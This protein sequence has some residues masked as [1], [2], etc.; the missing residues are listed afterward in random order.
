MTAQEIMTSPARTCSPEMSIAAVARIMRDNDYGAAIVVDTDGRIMGLLTDRDISLAVANSSLADHETDA[1]QTLP[2]ING[3]GRLV[4]IISL[5]DI[6]TR[7]AYA[8]RADDGVAALA[9]F[10]ERRLVR[11]ELDAA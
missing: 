1:D 6:V 3:A 7:G 11:R 10:C 4:G 5:D 9:R 2:V 8:V